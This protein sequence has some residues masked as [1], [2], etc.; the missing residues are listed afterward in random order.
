MP[1]TLFRV[2]GPPEVRI[3]VADGH[4]NFLASL[5]DLLSLEKDFRVVVR[6]SDGRVVLEAIEEHQ[7]DILLL[8]LGLPGSGGWTALKQLWTSQ[9]KTK[10]IVLAA[11]K[12]KAQFV[13]AMRFGAR[14][15]V[16]RQTGAD[17]LIK[18][19]RKVHAGEIWLDSAT[20]VAVMRQFSS[21]RE[22]TGPDRRDEDRIRLSRRESEFVKLVAQGFRNKEIAQKLSVSEQTVKNHLHNIFDKLAVSDRLELAL[23]AVHQ[24]ISPPPIPRS[25]GRFG[26]RPAADADPLRIVGK[27]K[28]C[29]TGW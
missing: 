21:R 17:L 7:P 18:S 16:M 10:V 9:A 12:N 28:Q 19:I 5:C 22:S 6:T 14:G 3:A 15:V 23:Y 13:Q 2:P 8:D 25:A 29:G 1:H 11:S 4:P 20:M 26:A 24:N 27:L